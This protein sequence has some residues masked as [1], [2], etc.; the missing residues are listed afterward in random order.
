VAS[1]KRTTTTTTTPLPK[2]CYQTQ[3]RGVWPP[4]KWF[5]RQFGLIS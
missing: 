5:I 2:K 1:A 3:W 4:W